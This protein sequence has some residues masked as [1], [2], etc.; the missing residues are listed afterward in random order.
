MSENR[1]DEIT[2]GEEPPRGSI[3]VPLAYA[4]GKMLRHSSWK[5]PNGRMLSDI[6]AVLDNRGW[7]LFIELARSLWPIEWPDIGTGQ[8]WLYSSVCRG[9]DQF[10]VALARHALDRHDVEIDSK[11]DIIDAVVR[12]RK[13]TCEA[14][15]TGD[16]YRQFVE[17]WGVDASATLHWLDTIAASKKEAKP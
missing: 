5:F 12:Y 2:F 15:L 4:Q 11:N 1:I 3:C 13:L 8:C 9:S 10:A 14:R 7:V 6:D 16:E 17:M